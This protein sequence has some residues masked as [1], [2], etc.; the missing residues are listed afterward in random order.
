MQDAT[1]LVKAYI[2]IRDAKAAKQKE[3]DEE[4]AKLDESLATIQAELLAICKET[5]QD[6]GKTAAGSFTRSVKT[7]Y[8]PSDWDAVYSLIREQNLPE[9]L[10]KRISQSNF[11]TFIEDNPDKMPA[12]MNVDRTYSITVRRAS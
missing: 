2:K 6:G 10:E 8:W 1:K 9:L 4:V 7:R 3:F 5:G 12:G 11:A